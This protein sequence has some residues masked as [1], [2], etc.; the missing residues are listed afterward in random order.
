[1]D[2]RKITDFSIKKLRGSTLHKIDFCKQN[3]SL[4]YMKKNCRE[5][6]AGKK[7]CRKKCF[8]FHVSK[9]TFF[10]RWGYARGF[11]FISLI[12]IHVTTVK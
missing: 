9:I 6:I 2:L 7:N 3:I 4:F 1:M 10:G 8:F 5:K 12:Q 11:C